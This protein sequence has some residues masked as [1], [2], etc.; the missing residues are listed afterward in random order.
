MGSMMV[1]LRMLRA[2]PPLYGVSSRPQ[3]WCSRIMACSGF[4][5]QA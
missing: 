5:E 1:G 4:P 2:L 3:G